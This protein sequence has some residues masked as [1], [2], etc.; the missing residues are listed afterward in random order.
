MNLFGDKLV[1]DIIRD[2]QN[3]RAFSSSPTGR[4][5]FSTFAQVFL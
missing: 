5:V 3:I 4:L 2:L 1:G